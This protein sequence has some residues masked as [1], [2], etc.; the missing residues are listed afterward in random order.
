[1]TPEEADLKARNMPS[2]NGQAL[3]DKPEQEFTDCF[4]YVG[5]TIYNALYT[6]IYGYV[7]SVS[8]LLFRLLF[9]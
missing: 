9:N 7:C 6:S 4:G 1:M 2:C 5:L 3:F 8:S